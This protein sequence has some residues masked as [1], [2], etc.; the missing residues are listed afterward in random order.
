MTMYGVFDGATLL[1]QYTDP[2]GA[3]EYREAAEAYGGCVG[4]K[5]TEVCE[6]GEEHQSDDCPEQRDIELLLRTLNCLKS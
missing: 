6:C 4:L 1:T 5:V 3:E 2:S